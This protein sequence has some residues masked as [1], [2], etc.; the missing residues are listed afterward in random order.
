VSNCDGSNSQVVQDTEC[1]VPISILKDTPFSLA[2]GAQVW[3][4]V[5]AVNFYG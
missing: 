5:T 1:F 3:A 2:W 4:K